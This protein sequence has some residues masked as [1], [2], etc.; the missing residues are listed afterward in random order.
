MPKKPKDIRPEWLDICE[1]I[2]TQIDFDFPPRSLVY[3]VATVEGG[4]PVKIEIKEGMKIEPRSQ[5]LNKSYDWLM[6][7]RRLQSVSRFDGM[8]LMT[9]GINEDK[10]PVWWSE[11]EFR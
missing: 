8:V 11:P 10:K 6:P 5:S 2:K 4:K 3:L 7:I 9:I 1:K